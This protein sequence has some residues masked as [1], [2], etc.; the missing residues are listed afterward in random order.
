MKIGDL[1]STNPASLELLNNGVAFVKDVVTPEE[2]EELRRAGHEMGFTHVEFMPVAEHAFYPSWGYQVTGFYAPTS[3]YG[4]PEDF[5]YLVNALHEAGL[6][7]IID[8]VPAHFPRDDW[9]LARFDGTAARPR[10]AVERTLKHVR[11]Q[12]INDE[13]GK[14]LVSAGDH[15]IKAALKGKVALATEVGKLVAQKALKA[16]IK[17]VVF[18]RRSYRYHGRVKAV[19]DGAREGGLIF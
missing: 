13:T 10:L 3:R 18:D 17:T 12:V 7:V 1:F 15:E 6:G 8:W 19:A 5:Q 16:G 2:F 4:P 11:V 14:T 9:A